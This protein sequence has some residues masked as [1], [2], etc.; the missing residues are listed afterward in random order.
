[1][2]AGGRVLRLSWCQL[3]NNFPKSETKPKRLDIFS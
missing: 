2:F 3:P 1:M